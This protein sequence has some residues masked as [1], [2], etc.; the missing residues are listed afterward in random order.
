MGSDMRRYRT[1]FCL[2]LLPA[3]WVALS[4]NA[5]AADVSGLWASDASQCNKMFVK[6]GRSVVFARNSDIHGSGFIIEGRKIRGPTARCDIKTTKEDGAM[7]HLLASCAT[8]VMLSN[9]QLSLRV[10]DENKVARI[11]PGVSDME[12]SYERCALK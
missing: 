3:C 9:V 11:F 10:I 12:M 5:P 7:V 4:A 8:D 1:A 2:F 6:K